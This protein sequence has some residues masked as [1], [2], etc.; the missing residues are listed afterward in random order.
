MGRK[1]HG[2]QGSEAA[3][4]Q[5]HACAYTDALACVLPRGRS[6]AKRWISAILWALGTFLVMALLI[7]IPYG[8][9]RGGGQGVCPRRPRLPCCVWSHA[10]LNAGADC[11]PAPAACAALAGYADIPT[12]GAWSGML[13]VQY[14]ETLPWSRCVGLFTNYDTNSPS[15]PP[16]LNSTLV[17]VGYAVRC[18]GW[19]IRAGRGWRGS[20][21]CYSRTREGV[22]LKC[23]I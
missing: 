15:N 21:P 4:R 10:A 23:G 12:Q 22:L 8:G 7:T 13:P 6:V 3:G 2:M 19:G 20:L 16:R 5:V 14:V 17:Q 11:V 9:C 18:S 1:T